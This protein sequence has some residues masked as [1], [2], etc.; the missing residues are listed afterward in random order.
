MIGRAGGACAPAP[1]PS[2]GMLGQD[3]GGYARIGFVMRIFAH[4]IFLE[5][6]RAD[7]LADIV[8]IRADA[9]QQRVRADSFR[10]RA[11]A[12]LATTME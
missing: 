4:L 12:R 10:R 9:G 11:S 8:V 2:P 1:R 7:E 6:H 3:R 5:I